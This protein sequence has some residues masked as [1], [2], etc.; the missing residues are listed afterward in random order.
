MLHDSHLDRLPILQ[1]FDVEVFTRWCFDHAIVINSWVKTSIFSYYRQFLFMSAL[2]L[3]IVML[4]IG[5]NLLHRAAIRGSV[6]FIDLYFLSWF[7]LTEINLGLRIC[8]SKISICTHVESRINASLVLK[9][10]FNYM[11]LT[12]S[13]FN[14]AIQTSSLWIINGF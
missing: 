10:L 1:S 14:P 4:F 11:I 13:S 7:D 8:L 9:I 12:L 5:H 6:N 2:T 3:Y